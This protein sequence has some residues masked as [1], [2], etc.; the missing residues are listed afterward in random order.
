MEPIQPQPRF[1]LQLRLSVPYPALGAG[2]QA[3]VEGR[4]IVLTE[5]W[6]A[7]RIRLSRAEALLPQNGRL[8]FRVHFSGTFGGSLLLS[9]KPVL[10][11]LYAVRLAEP[12]Y[13]LDSQSL[14]LR[15]ARWMFDQKILGLLGEKAVYD[16]KPHVS[17][18]LAAANGFGKEAGGWKIGLGM[19][20][21]R[22]TGIE[23]EED[24]LVILARSAGAVRVWP[25]RS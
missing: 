5:G 18:V 8:R 25:P 10:E 22:L 21:L 13:E 17:T 20:D 23:V 3:A 6:L 7:Q 19:E 14:L 12:A 4:E 24:G 2:L 9:G 15:T 1:D 11:S 16:L